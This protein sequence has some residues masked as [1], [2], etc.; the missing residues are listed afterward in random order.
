MNLK[1]V[2]TGF[3]LEVKWNG[4]TKVQVLLPANYKHQTCG[5][6][7]DYDGSPTNDFLVGPACP[8]HNVGSVVI[9]VWIYMTYIFVTNE[10]TLRI[11]YGLT[12]SPYARLRLSSVTVFFT[13][14]R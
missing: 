2:S 1:A 12:I 5:I 8:G 11:P 6:C 7:G 9:V 10:H 14:I 13:D 4:K 3:G